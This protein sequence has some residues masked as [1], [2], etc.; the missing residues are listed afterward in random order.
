[1]V[2]DND[3]SYHSERGK[4]GTQI[5]RI[6]LRMIIRKAF[7]WQSPSQFKSNMY[8]H[9]LSSSSSTTEEVMSGVISPILQMEKLRFRVSRRSKMQNLVFT[10]R[11]EPQVGTD[12]SQS[13]GSKQVSKSLKDRNLGKKTFLMV[14]LGQLYTIQSTQPSV[15]DILMEVGLNPTAL[16]NKPTIYSKSKNITLQELWIGIF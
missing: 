15:S 7:S 12:V 11:D 2:C 14:S 5:W 1:M 8:V 3:N 4:S 16:Q 6:R 9:P 10:I 13:L